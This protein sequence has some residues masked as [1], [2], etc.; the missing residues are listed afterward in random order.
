VRGAGECLVSRPDLPVQVVVVPR[1]PALPVRAVNGPTKS[2]EIH[3]A[4]AHD[5]PA[6]GPGGAQGDGWQTVYSAGWDELAAGS[7]LG[8]WGASEPFDFELATALSPD[9]QNIP[10]TLLWRYE[11]N[12]ALGE[13]RRRVAPGAEGCCIDHPHVNP[14]FEGSAECRFV[15]ASVSNELP[16]SGPPCGYVKVD[17]KAGTRAVWWAGNRT[18]C[19]EPVIVPKADGTE[20]DDVW[21]LGI[22]CD[23][24]VNDKGGESSLLI[25]DGARL[26]DGPVARVWLGERL[27]HGLH[28]CFTSARES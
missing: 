9:F 5:G 4:L 21:L 7:F 11:V 3:T 23:H 18:F 14:R 17:V 1:D 26:A 8:E 24:T 20:E 15:F 2:F 6:S 10:A 12:A 19:E 25:L 27:P 16:R 28:G 13:V 22:A